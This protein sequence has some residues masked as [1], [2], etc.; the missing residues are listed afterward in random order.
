MT[1]SPPW[2]VAATA[3][4]DAGCDVVIGLPSD[5]PG[6]MDAAEAQD[7]MRVIG[8]RDQRVG[9]CAAIG[10][11]TSTGRPAVLAVESGPSFAN[12]LTGLLEASS[13]GAPIVVV[14]TRVPVDEIGRGAFQYT[15]QAGMAASLTK[16]R[17]LVERPQQLV[18][19][20]RRAVHLA[21]NGSPGVV[22]V[23]IAHEVLHATVEPPA[24]QG[25]VRRLRS[26]AAPEDVRAAREL[27]T[28]A[29]LPVLLA[30]GGCATPHA[31]AGLRRLAE[32]LGAPVFTT[33]AGRG[34][35]DEQHPLACGLVGLYTTPPAD[36]L[37]ADADVVVA[38]G[39][40]LEETARM[41]W[42]SF[43]SKRLIH[44]DATPDAFLAALEPAVAL[45]GDAGVVLDQLL[46]GLVPSPEA[47]TGR[48]AHVSSVREE[49]ARRYASP[50]VDA[51]QDAAPD[52][53]PD[54]DAALT[55]RSAL[56]LLQ[57][58]FDAP[59]TVV[60]ENGLHDMWGYHFPVLT[61]GEDTRVIVPGEQTMV[62]FGLPAAV[63][64]AVADPARR[65]VLV[66]GDGALE[67]S[68]SALATAAEQRCGITVLVLDNQGYGWPRL[69]RTTAG[70]D[71]GATRF[72]AP[73]LGPAAVLASG[74]WTTVVT[75]TGELRAALAEAAKVTA[76]GR[77]AVITVPVD[78]GDVPVGV[79]GLLGTPEEHT[80]GTPATAAPASA[81]A[82]RSPGARP[83]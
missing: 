44:I 81:S 10:H 47:T 58:T 78:D 79:R 22:L 1:Q 54:P 38:V 64:A 39:S 9:A 57:E 60:Q 31:H 51:D 32:A 13:L 49:M 71:I 29:R 77:T 2:H 19:A 5:E 68:T 3:L 24:A 75:T 45:L 61:V 37:L 40:R 53:A 67:M 15:D 50:G 48:A 76:D 30:G 73:S 65:T 14:T 7:R 4:A 27:L 82:P 80:P 23:E 72:R 17:F 21:V 25:P 59:T 33:A 26:A 16:W 8:V 43:G 52:A 74:G 41:G 6:L 28:T 12:T 62:G 66:C 46:E 35:F 42:D 36:G 11:A 18:W 56:G 34:A 69:L 20:L 70:A 55:V 83:S 63:G